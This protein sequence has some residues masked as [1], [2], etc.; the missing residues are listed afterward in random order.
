MSRTRTRAA[1]PCSRTA[2][3]C[4]ADQVIA[5]AAGRPGTPTGFARLVEAARDALPLATA[6][7][8]EVAAQVLE[9][10][11]EAESG[12]SARQPGAGR[13]SPTCAASCPR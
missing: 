4:A 2:R 10:A 9:A 6:E 7:V 5:E 8:V 13:R 3:P 1:A 12:C 11:H